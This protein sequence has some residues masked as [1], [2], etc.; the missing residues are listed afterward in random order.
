MSYDQPAAIGGRGLWKPRTRLKI[1]SGLVAFQCLTIGL[2][3][4]SSYEGV[5]RWVN[6]ALLV[7]NALLALML[8]LVASAARPSLMLVGA[9]I[10]AL[11]ARLGLGGVSLGLMRTD[12]GAVVVVMNV[13]FGAAILAFVYVTMRAIRAESVRE[14]LS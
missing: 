11:L 12:P 13:L 3:L 10:A 14:A 5:P 8:W 4:M 1:F 2:Q 9:T 6:V 7:G